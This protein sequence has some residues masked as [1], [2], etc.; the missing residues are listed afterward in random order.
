MIW[1]IVFCGP[2][3]L[4]GALCFCPDSR[5][6]AADTPNSSL[7]RIDAVVQEA[8][9]RKQLPGAVIL[10]VHRGEVVYRKAL[11]SRCVEP[12]AAP[13]TTDTLFDL[14]SLT[15]PIATA[16]S[17]MILMERGKLQ[18]SDTVAQHLAA[19]AQHGKSAITV[20]QLLLHTSGLVADN[21]E[22]D[23]REGKVKAL[24][25]IH[26]LAPVAEPGTRFRYSDV[27]YIVLGELVEHL[28]GMPLDQFAQQNIFAPL[29]MNE[30]AFRPTG[31][32]AKR[33][34]PTQQ[35]NGHWMIG[36][37]H[38]PRAYLLGGVAGH[39]GLFS[40]ADDLAI[41]TQ[42]LLGEGTYKG[43]RILSGA[44][45]RAMMAPRP[46]PGGLRAYGWDVQTAFSSNR[47]QLFPRGKS[48]G[49]TGFTGTSIWIDPTSATAVIFLSNRVHPNGKG[50][51]KRLR[52]EV[53]T[54]AA[55][56][57]R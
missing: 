20:E 8:I 54:L 10:I 11:G 55:A 43:K 50:D 21:P 30:T 7:E 18:I 23:Y 9:A 57:C 4:V 46:V 39:A 53:A 13:M 40:T 33:A 26:E 41:C 31:N 47:G 38:D 32:L 17:L 2:L 49:H 14:A 15:K 45:A 24:A 29:G 34:A 56:A 6:S 28:A 12:V 42:M 51:V 16:T 1:S 36:E 35:R 5:C 25:R 52:G 19:F 44:T 22:T 48:F 27:N 37:V 3:F